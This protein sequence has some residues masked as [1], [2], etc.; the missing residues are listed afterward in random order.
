LDTFGTSYDTFIAVW[1]KNANGTLSLVTCNDNSAG[2][3]QSSINLGVVSGTTYYI[4]VAQ[5]NTSSVPTATP[6]GT[7][8]FHRTTFADV[9]GRSVFWKYVEGLYEAGITAGCATTPNTL[10]CPSSNV[11]R[12]TMAVFLLKSRHGASYAPPAVGASTGF[13][14]V[15]TTYWAAAW[16]KQLAAEGITS[17]CGNGNYCPTNPVSRAQMAIFLLRAKHGTSYTPPAVGGSTGF[18][19]VPTDYWAAAWIKQLAAEGVT[20]GCGTNIYCPGSG[21]TREQMAV[22]LSRTFSIPT[23]P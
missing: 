8:Q 22:F 15:P 17:G 20:A 9:Q 3:L 23:H 5:K 1:T 13:T 21:V 14:D 6:G 2:T 18:T 4:Q 12:A 10:Y 16:I 19:D 7:L 11:D